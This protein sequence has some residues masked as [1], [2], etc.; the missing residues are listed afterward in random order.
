M[1]AR[2]VSL[3][4]IIECDLLIGV[5]EA[6]SEETNA[7]ATID[8]PFLSARIRFARVVNEARYVTSLRC[9]D[10]LRGMF[11]LSQCTFI[12]VLRHWAAS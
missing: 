11:Y 8:R 9:V 4:L 3:E 1:S 12:N 6:I 7:Q 10:Y 2:P 5:N